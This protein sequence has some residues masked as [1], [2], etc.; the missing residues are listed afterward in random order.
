MT[1]A[2]GQPAVPQAAAAVPQATAAVPQATAA[3]PQAT[4]AVPQA[5][6]PRSGPAAAT[7]KAPLRGA[8]VVGGDSDADVA[9]QLT[10]IKEQAANGVAPDPSPPD[11]ALATA[12]V[13]AAIDYG[14]RG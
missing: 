12:K 4:A 3:V 10:R 7:V 9:A 13:R 1:A 8:L 14:R 11:P 5:A 2:S 6:G